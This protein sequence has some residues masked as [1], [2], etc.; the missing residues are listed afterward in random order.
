MNPY[1]VFKR[2]AMHPNTLAAIGAADVLR[3][4][5]PRIVELEGRF[6]IRLRTGRNAVRLPLRQPHAHHSDKAEG[7][8]RA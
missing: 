1:R 8:R 5:D 6:E 7:L 2:T 3:Q 4:L